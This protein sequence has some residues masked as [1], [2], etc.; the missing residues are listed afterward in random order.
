M[1]PQDLYLARISKIGRLYFATM[2]AKP[3]RNEIINDPFNLDHGWKW[4]ANTLNLE[5]MSDISAIMLLDFLEICGFAMFHAYRNQFEFI[6]A[7]V[8]KLNSIKEVLLMP[9]DCF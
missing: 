7:S 9:F 5:N 3:R 8:H 2:I 6:L 1:E 4:I